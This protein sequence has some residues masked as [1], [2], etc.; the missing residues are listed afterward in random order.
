[1]AQRLR[2]GDVVRYQDPHTSRQFTGTVIGHPHY[3]AEHDVVVIAPDPAQG[4]IWEVLNDD[5]CSQPISRD[6]LRARRE[7]YRLRQA[8][9]HGF[10][11]KPPRGWSR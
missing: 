9:P 10:L 11:Q 3:A 4:R 6:P 2:I 8:A 7:R 5:W 1:M